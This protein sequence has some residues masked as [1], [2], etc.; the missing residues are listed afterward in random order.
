MFEDLGIK[1]VGPVDGH[2]EAAMER[3]L[4]RAKAFGAPVIVHA[5]TEKGHGYTPAEQ[6]VA[7]RFHAVGQIHPETGLPVAPSRFGWTSVFADEI[8]RIGRR[9]PDVVAVTAA[10]LHPVGLAPFAKEFPERTFDVGIAEQHAVTFAA[11]CP[12]TPRA[13]SPSTTSSRTRT[14]PPP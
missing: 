14:P 8:V 7:D 13:P 10:M 6:D 5:I 12:A 9:R 4:R 1:Y 11:G 2:D 3:A